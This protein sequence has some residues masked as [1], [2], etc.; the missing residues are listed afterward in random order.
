[1]N[2]VIAVIIVMAAIIVSVIGVVHLIE[3][4]FSEKTSL[5]AEND[6]LHKEANGY[7]TQMQSMGK[8]IAEKDAKIDHHV[9]HIKSLD[10]RLETV[11]KELDFFNGEHGNAEKLR[12][13]FCNQLMAMISEYRNGLTG[14][15]NDPRECEIPIVDCESLENLKT[16]E[17]PPSAKCV[18][19]KS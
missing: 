1:M 11:I 2:L 17:Q 5:A 18:I 3:R 16:K 7:K 15:N 13:E 8:L 14:V 9:R 4:R 10:A 12:W 19:D 6:E